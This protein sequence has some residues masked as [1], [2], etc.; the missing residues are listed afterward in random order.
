[1]W[2]FL[3]YKD[4]G[5][6]WNELTEEQKSKYKDIVKDFSKAI[7]EANLEFIESTR[8]NG[9]GQNTFVF[10]SLNENKRFVEY[11]AKCIHERT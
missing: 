2:G 7:T 9:K 1:M 5:N 11:A 10:S 3:K 8:V 4:M 6:N